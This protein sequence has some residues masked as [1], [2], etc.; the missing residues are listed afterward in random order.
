MM[1]G[2]HG[3]EKVGGRFMARLF[4]LAAP[5]HEQAV[6]ET[7]KHAHHQH[8]MGLAHSAEIVVVRDIQTL[9]QATF[10]P[11]GGAIVIGPRSVLPAASW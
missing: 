5:M 3:G 2:V 6:A 9:V 8:G 7:A 4:L 10:N 11:P 1:F